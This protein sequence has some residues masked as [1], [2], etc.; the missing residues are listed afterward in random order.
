[1]K[2]AKR[3]ALCTRPLTKGPA[4]GGPMSPVWILKHLVSVFILSLSLVLGFAIT[5]A[6]LPREVVSCRNFILR[7]VSTFWVMTLVGIYPGRA[8]I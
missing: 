1:M 8:S 2:L 5:V 4:R 3:Q 7:S 6:I